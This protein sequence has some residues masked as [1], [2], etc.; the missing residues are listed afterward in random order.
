MC[1][2][3][4]RIHAYTQFRLLNKTLITNAFARHRK[5]LYP[6]IRCSQLVFVDELR[7]FP[8]KLGHYITEVET[9]STKRH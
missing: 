1:R 3:H 2:L 9:M 8:T 7:A 5:M 4:R 6:S